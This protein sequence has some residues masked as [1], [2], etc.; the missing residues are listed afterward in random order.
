MPQDHSPTDGSPDDADRRWFLRSVATAAAGGG[1]ASI[2]GDRDLVQPVAAS[3]LASVDPA[4]VQVDATAD[5][6]EVFP[7]SVMSG[8]PTP[9]GAIAWTRVA[10]SAAAGNGFL[11]LQVATDPEFADVQHS[12]VIPNGRYAADHDHTVQVDL[13][14][15]L[16]PDSFYHYRFVYDGTA[17]RTGRLRTLP[18]PD[19]SPE[20]LRVAVV[21]CQDYQNGYYG[22]HHHVAQEELDYLVHLGDFVYESANGQYTAPGRSVPDDR[23]LSLPS[24]R[25]LA[26]T[27]DDFRYLYD[28]YKRD[29]FLQEALERHTVIAGWDDHEVGNDRYWDAAADAPVLPNK[30]RGDDPEFA[31]EV[32]ANGIQAWVEHVPMRVDYDPSAEHLHDQLRLWRRLEFGDLVDLAVTDERLFRDGPPCPG[33]DVVTCFREDE[34]GRTMLGDEQKQWWKDWTKNS[35]ARWTTWLNEVLT[36][37]LTHGEGWNQVEVLHDAWD[38][39]QH[40]RHQLMRHLRRHG[41]RN[42]VTLT[43]DLHCA[44]AG[45][46]HGHYGE[47]GRGDRGPRVGVE[48]LTPAISSTNAADVLTYPTWLDDEDVD[49]FA[50]AEN[51]HLTFVD[52]HEHGYAVVEFTRDEARYTAYSVDS[53]E[54]SEDATRRTLAEYVV[55]DGEHRLRRKR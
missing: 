10:P 2:L 38:G 6:D 49:D 40:E 37:P 28:R 9:T 18:E 13:D 27:L 4:S 31:M 24:G 44:M 20:S 5:P 46:Q 15:E 47:F 26:E 22:A 29:R 23:Q 45:I 32:T 39:F 21:S 34:R 33:G 12:T 48:L 55:P 11:V 36:M 50:T 17:T 52:W 1:L 43:G 16:T 51:E 25:P 8:G 30:R 35:T 7:Q 42:F 14:G 3:D 53:T 41:P 54:N 19:A